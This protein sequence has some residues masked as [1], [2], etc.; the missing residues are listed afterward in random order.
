MKK[1]KLKRRIQALLA[2][3]ALVLAALVLPP[4]PK[5]RA[6][7]SRIQTVNHVGSVSMTTPSTNALP[8]TTTK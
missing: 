2:F 5:P 7:A 4:L 8:D 3:I 6:R 1:K